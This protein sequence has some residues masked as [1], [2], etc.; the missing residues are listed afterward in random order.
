MECSGNAVFSRA[1]NFR[2]Y[3]YCKKREII[4]RCLLS[5]NRKKAS[6]GLGIRTQLLYCK[7]QEGPDRTRAGNK[8]YFPCGNQRYDSQ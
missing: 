5:G 8:Y 3:S 1:V 6:T 7:K 2:E 4:F